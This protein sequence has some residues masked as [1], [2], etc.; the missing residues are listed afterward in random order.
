MQGRH[1]KLTIETEILHEISNDNGFRVVNFSTSK[2]PTVKSTIF[3]HH[4]INKYT[5]MSPD[6]KPHSQIDH[7]LI[8]WLIQVYLILV[9]LGQEIMVLTII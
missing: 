9:H 8:D 4:N 3:P 2:N 7:I 1:F 6:Q 5:W